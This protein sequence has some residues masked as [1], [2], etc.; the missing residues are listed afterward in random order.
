MSKDK[1][2]P[3]LAEHEIVESPRKRPGRIADVYSIGYSTAGDEFDGVDDDTDEG[4]TPGEDQTYT[5]QGLRVISQKLNR[6]DNGFLFVDVVLGWDPLPGVS[7][8][9]VRISSDES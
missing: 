4:D 5:P 3:S 9:R 1:H 7:E 8:Y 2:R 6:R